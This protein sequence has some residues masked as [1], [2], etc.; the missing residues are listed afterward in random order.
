M[1][2]WLDITGYE[3]MYQVS[4][5]GRVRNRNTG[6]ILKPLMKK[7]YQ[8]VNLYSNKKMKTHAIHRLVAQAFIPN[9]QQLPQVNHK[10]ENK[11]NNCAGNL[12]WCTAYY[13]N[14]Y[15]TRNKR[16]SDSVKALSVDRK[17][18]RKTRAVL[19]IEKSSGQVVKEYRSITEAAKANGFHR[20]NIYWCCIG[21]RN[22]ASGYLW[23]YIE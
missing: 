23:E 19:Q 15:G 9:L 1:E 4:S 6:Y 13:N 20:G 21:K 16:I 12:E 5:L 14:N 22:E 10:D 8:V 2:E 3:N 17:Y 7:G 18:L 11:V